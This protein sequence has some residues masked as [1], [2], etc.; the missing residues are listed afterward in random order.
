MES[1]KLS[2]AYIVSGELAKTLAMSAVCTRNS[3][4]GGTGSSSGGAGM[5]AI[6]AGMDAGG[7]GAN[8]AIAVEGPCRVCKHCVKVSRG[9]HPD[10]IPISVEDGKREITVD[11][12]RALKKYLIVIPN[13]AERKVYVIN[14]ADL[15]NR[16][17]QNALLQALEEPPSYTVFI[18]KTDNPAALLPTVRSRCITVHTRQD[19]DT[20]LT[21]GAKARRSAASAEMAGELF[22]ALENGNQALIVLMFKLEKLDKEAFAGFLSAGRRQAASRLKDAAQGKTGLPREV[23]ANAERVL[24]KA[25]EMLDLNVSPGHLSGMICASLMTD[26]KNS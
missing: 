8:G 23:I 17:A 22:S 24:L 12:I 18:L 19:A 14:D 1:I 5:D 20:A 15:M 2:H 4:T 6:D 3:G 13:E 9:V 11:Q 25:G 21:A 10:V 26:N 16:N 7:S